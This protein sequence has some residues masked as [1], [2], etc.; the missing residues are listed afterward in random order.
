MCG[1]K[2]LGSP[3]KLDDRRVRYRCCQIESG[4]TVSIGDYVH[5]LPANPLHQ[6]Y[7]AKINDLFEVEEKMFVQVLWLYRQAELKHTPPCAPVENEIYHT[8]YYDCQLIQ[9]IVGPCLVVQYTDCPTKPMTRKEQD[10]STDLY[11]CRYSYSEESGEFV[12]AQLSDFD[13]NFCLVGKDHEE[14]ADNADSDVEELVDVLLQIE[15]DMPL[16]TATALWPARRMAWLKRV[17]A[18]TCL[19][20]VKEALIDL[21]N[22]FNISE[23]EPNWKDQVHACRSSDMLLCCIKK[24]SQSLQANGNVLNHGQLETSSL[25]RLI[26]RDSYRKEHKRKRATSAP[27]NRPVSKKRASEESSIFRGIYKLEEGCLPPDAPPHLKNLRVALVC[28]MSKDYVTIAYPSMASLAECFGE[29]NTG[30][31]DGSQERKLTSYLFDQTCLSTYTMPRFDEEFRMTLETALKALKYCISSSKY[32]KQG[33]LQSFWLKPGVYVASRT[34]ETQAN[35]KSRCCGSEELITPSL[36]SIEQ[37]TDDKNTLQ[38]IN[39]CALQK[40]GNTKMTDVFI[41]NN[42]GGERFEGTSKLPEDESYSYQN[43]ILNSSQKTIMLMPLDICDY[44]DSVFSDRHDTSTNCALVKECVDKQINRIA[45][46]GHGIVKWGIRKKTTYHNRFRG[47]AYSSDDVRP[48]VFSHKD[49]VLKEKFSELASSGTNENKH[50]S[51][52]CI[53][54]D[55]R[56]RKMLKV[57]KEMQGRWSSERYKAAQ[58]KLFQI[59]KDKGAVPGK[60]LLR[61]ALREEARKHIGDTGLLDHLLKHM[62]D[63]VINN[64]ERFRRRHNS[65]GA[66]EYWLEDARLQEMRKQA[67]VD[68]YW[69]P[70]PG[71]KFGDAIR[72]SKDEQLSD[73][74]LNEL[75]LLREDVEKLKSQLQYVCLHLGTGFMESNG[76]LPLG[77]DS[78][79]QLW[80]KIEN[81]TEQAQDRIVRCI[82][83]PVELS[84]REESAVFRQ[85]K[86]VPTQGNAQDALTTAEVWQANALEDNA[87]QQKVCGM[88]EESTAEVLQANALE[89][90]AS[91]Q[92]V[93]G[94]A[95]ESTEKATD[96]DEKNCGDEL[97]LFYKASRPCLKMSPV[98]PSKTSRRGSAEKK[99]PGSNVLRRSPRSA[100]KKQAGENKENVTSEEHQSKLMKSCKSPRVYHRH[101]LSAKSANVQLS[102]A[103]SSTQSKVPLKSGLFSNCQAPTMRV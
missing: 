24:L 88:A 65:E 2:W 7:L 10:I 67:G 90:N 44:G 56:K 98:N 78:G 80:K 93:C 83:Y 74:Q 13:H 64:G 6:L 77:R 38:L 52:T 63:T 21:E 16:Q 58:L 39:S 46:E 8:N 1:A 99:S 22:E 15:R 40:T 94:M 69:I 30:I 43:E 25:R 29:S 50:L 19:E 9:S 3:Q 76:A 73:S 70:P 71:W 28:D 5:M 35:K 12:E 81:P 72:N 23:L 4:V 31:E 101:V 79:F 82:E 47:N 18:A 26:L 75:R 87:S 53:T 49:R 95:E 103:T 61:P 60:P 27:M 36:N 51:M 97:F 92:K 54:T 62:T 68:Q 102:S 66:M 96:E 41:D 48:K 33:H 86:S 32:L 11:V 34:K 37:K 91:Q 45:E 14:Q 89:D 59:M 100:V 85:N 20:E 42:D 17:K 55:I 84:C 57:P